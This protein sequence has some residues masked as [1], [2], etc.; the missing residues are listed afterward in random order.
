[1]YL[2]K[3]N[4][5]D[6]LIKFRNTIIEWVNTKSE[7]E[8]PLDFLSWLEYDMFSVSD[9]D[10]HIDSFYNSIVGDV[11]NEDLKEIFDGVDVDENRNKISWL[12]FTQLENAE[13][14]VGYKYKK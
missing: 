10:Q 14:R 12:S 8:F 11:P 13:F 4:S 7:E 3:I 5:V 2:S 1:M 9:A 6:F